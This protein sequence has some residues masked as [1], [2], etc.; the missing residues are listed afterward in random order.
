[1]RRYLLS[2]EEQPYLFDNAASAVRWAEEISLRSSIKG[3][4]LMQKKGGG[5][6]FVELKDY[7]LSITNIANNANHGKIFI[8]IY[9]RF[10]TAVAITQADL[11]AHYLHQTEEG[12]KKQIAQLRGLGMAVLH[13]QH[14]FVN[15]QRKMSL[16]KIARK[17]GISKQAYIKSRSWPVLRSNAAEMV[18]QWLG[19]ADRD[20]TEKLSDMGVFG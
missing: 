8:C 15:Y 3:G 7:A 12:V 20:I 19:E 1:M 14:I 11:I 10:N 6:P 2:E 16:S 5:L 4:S 18:N 17:C 13:D 9:S